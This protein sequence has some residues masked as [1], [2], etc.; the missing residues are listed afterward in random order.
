MKRYSFEREAVAINNRL[1]KGYPKGRTADD[2]Y[3]RTYQSGIIT[4]TYYGKPVCYCSECGSPI[5]VTTQKEC[6]ACHAKWT[7]EPTEDRQRR[8][9]EYHMVMQAKA[10][11]QL[12]R[13]YRVE[14][15]TR[16]GK[17]TTRFVWEVERI[18][19]APTG[20]RR[21]FARAV[22][23]M[24]GYYDAFSYG[25]R[26]TIKREGKGMTWSAEMRYSLTIAT[27]RI[28]SLTQQWRYKDVK[29][30]MTDYGNDT[31]VLKVLAYPWAETMIKTG[32][33]KLFRHLVNS[34]MLLP[35][36]TEHALNICT[37]NHYRIEDGGMWLDHLALLK[38]FGLDTHNAH[39]VCPPD[40]RAAHQELVERRRRERQ[41]I[42]AEKRAKG[43][44]A[45]LA[46][47]DKEKA[48]YVKRMGSMLGLLLTGDNLAIR[49]LQSVDEF[50]EEGAK[51]H[52]CVFENGYYERDNCLIL[53]AKDNEGHRLATIEYNTKR[54]E[55]EQCRAACNAVPERDAEIR[56]LITTHKQDF[57]RLLKAA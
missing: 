15:H 52:H 14:R 6:P 18:M 38:H 7:A 19:Y 39:Y 33:K 9:V 44:A 54:N 26:I 23:T 21:V 1:G 56:Q 57:A 8:E 53:S 35:K 51:M 34:G 4:R 43:Y 24:S 22:Q 31:S 10:D 27:Y 30:M 29:S 46:K 40:L 13:I 20:E 17:A 28:E 5:G 16:Y 12:C 37:R 32:Q 47:M 55:I 25:S 41:R 36:G 48:D 42:E 50:A 2:I 45:R 3:R 11:I 49:P